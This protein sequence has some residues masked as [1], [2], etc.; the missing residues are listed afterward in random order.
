MR[1]KKNIKLMSAIFIIAFFFKYIN[2][3]ICLFYNIFKIPC[4]SCGMTRAITEI[5]KGN[6]LESF[7][8]NILAFPLIIIILSLVLFSLF[9]KEEELFKLANQHKTFLITITALILIITLVI[10]I[11]NPLLYES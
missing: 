5:I 10:N 2:F 7:R 8:Y 6:I 4:P 1:N 9:N 3:R 11:N